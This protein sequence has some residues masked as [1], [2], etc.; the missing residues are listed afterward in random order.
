M[1]DRADTPWNTVRPRPRSTWNTPIPRRDL[2]FKLD[3]ILG[4]DGRLIN[5]MGYSLPA[6]VEGAISRLVAQVA[7]QAQELERL[8]SLVTCLQD[9]V[10]EMRSARPSARRAR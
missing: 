1:G 4:A 10:D 5:Q 6:D 8:G 3:K 2:A 7:A 9:A